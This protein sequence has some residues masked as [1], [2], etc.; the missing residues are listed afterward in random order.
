[1]DDFLREIKHSRVEQ[2]LEEINN[3]YT[4]ESRVCPQNGSGSQFFISQQAI[5]P[6]P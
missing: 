4:Q 2:K 5:N 1:M 3:N 6:G